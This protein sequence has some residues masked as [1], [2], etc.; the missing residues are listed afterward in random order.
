[1]FKEQFLAA[2]G[3]R[4]RSIQLLNDLFHIVDMDMCY[5]GWKV[6]IP[7]RSLTCK[8]YL[9]K[10]GD[11]WK[12]EGIASQ[13]DLSKADNV[14]LI[15][16]SFSSLWMWIQILNCL[17]LHFL[18]TSGFYKEMPHVWWHIS[19]RYWS[20]WLWGPCAEPSSGVPILQWDLWKVQSAGVWWPY[21][22]SWPG[23]ILNSYLFCRTGGRGHRIE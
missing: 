8:Y 17:Y 7:C 2:S 10:P 15:N 6:R 5:L 16:F 3:V 12:L 9:Q 1:M 4:M 13:K 20:K 18:C 14:W 22:L 21:F 11:I 23:I 19:W